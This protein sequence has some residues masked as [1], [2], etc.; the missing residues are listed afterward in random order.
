MLP[1]QADGEALRR[2]QVLSAGGPSA[3]SGQHSACQSSPQLPPQLPGGHKPSTPASRRPK[4]KPAMNVTK[5]HDSSHVKGPKKQLLGLFF[6]ANVFGPIFAAV[7]TFHTAFWKALTR[8]SNPSGFGNSASQGEM[9][10]L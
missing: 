4:A 9:R 3:L 2:T 8:N 6:K 1:G 10:S 5:S 7:F